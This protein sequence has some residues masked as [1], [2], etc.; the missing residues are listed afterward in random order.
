M[1]W[2]WVDTKY[3]ILLV[4]HSLSTAYTQDCLS[5]LH[6]HGYEL[7][8]EC[9]FSFERTSLHD[10]LPSTSSPWQL[11]GNVTLSHS[12]SC[13]LTNWWIVSAPGAPSID[14]LQVLVQSWSN[15]ASKCVCKFARSRPRS[16][17][18]NSLHYRLHVCRIITSKCISKHGQLRPPSLYDHGLQ[19]HISKATWSRPPSASP[20]SLD[21]GLQ[22]RPIITSK[23]MS[24]HA[25]L[26]PPS[27]HDHV[28]QVH[29]SKLNRPRHPNVSPNLLDYHLQVY[30]QLRS[31]T[32]SKC[33]SPNSLNQGLG[34][35]LWVHLIFIFRRTSNC[36]QAPQP[37]QIYLM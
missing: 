10:R 21:Y 32:A 3:S 5:S 15:T 18:P 13:K 14:R 8:P 30:L 1:P 24:K 27:S 6:S 23:I 20:N 16:V 35:Y 4:Q 34:V 12:Q 36:T 11:N 7:T 25:L 17:P 37:V 31:I 26:R 9:S 29:I 22:I 19:V 28:L 33:I 2:S